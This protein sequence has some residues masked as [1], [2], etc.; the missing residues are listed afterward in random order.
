[1]NPYLLSFILIFWCGTMSYA[2]QK[3]SVQF[4]EAHLPFA[5]ETTLNSRFTGR[6]YRIQI[7]K[8]GAQPATGYPVLYVLDGDA[9]F[10]PLASA[11]QALLVNPISGSNSPALIVGIGYSRQKLLD[12]Q[13]RALD[14]TPPLAPNA[15]AELKKQFGQA[16]AF[17]LFI[18]R[19]LKPLLAQSAVIDPKR[20]ALFGHSYGGLFAAYNL[21]RGNGRF[22]YFILSSPS[23]WWQNKRLLDFIPDD[24]NFKANLKGV[25][26]RITVGQLERARNPRNED[27]RQA[28]DML[29][30]AEEFFQTLKKQ[31]ADAEFFIY[32]DENHGSV[33]YKSLTD[34]LKFLQPQWRTSA[35]H[36]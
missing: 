11:A 28:R 30:N 8:I 24:A 26:V 9:L 25:K 19:E 35:A 33:V 6:T 36:P 14:Y 22:Q 27:K 1:M 34:A 7:S 23:I 29:G 13:Q 3:T 21:L 20:Q 31:G 18:E 16:D 12:L 15:E 4:A 5:Q 2:E 32:P 17:G 10:A